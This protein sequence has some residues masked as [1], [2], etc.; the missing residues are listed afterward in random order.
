M[1]AEVVVLVLTGLLVSFAVPLC[2]AGRHASVLNLMVAHL[3]SDHPA[4]ETAQLQE[5]LGHTP[6]QV[7]MGAAVGLLVGGLVTGLS[8]L[9]GS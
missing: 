9:L 8:S 5:T 1:T 2:L 3:P 6:L 4:A 7:V